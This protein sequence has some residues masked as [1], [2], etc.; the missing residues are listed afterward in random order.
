[1][2]L[3]MLYVPV[4]LL[5]QVRINVSSHQVMRVPVVCSASVELQSSSSVGDAETAVFIALQLVSCS[6]LKPNLP[7]RAYCNEILSLGPFINSVKRDA[8][9][10]RFGFTSPPSPSSRSLFL[11]FRCVTLFI[12]LFDYFQCILGSRHAIYERPGAKRM[13]FSRR[14]LNPMNPHSLLPLAIEYIHAAL[15]SATTSCSDNSV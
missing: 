1:M 3:R 13:T 10:F 11:E 12:L 8:A 14:R 7:C 5:V 6:N 4:L 2:C 15:R 9:C